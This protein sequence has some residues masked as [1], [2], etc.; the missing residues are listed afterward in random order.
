MPTP[1]I[2]VSSGVAQGQLIHQVTPVYPAQAKLA[3]INGTVVLQAVV[4]KDGSV[5]KV[6]ALRGPPILI[7][8]A[9]QAVRQWRYKPFAVNGEPA[10]AD[11]E[12]S[13]KFAPYQ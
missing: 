11:I 1:R 3:Q 9:L 13:L 4:G 7:E 10:E 6:K 12:I 5:T 2:R 8:S